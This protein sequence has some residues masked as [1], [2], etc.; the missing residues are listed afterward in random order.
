MAGR[1]IGRRDFLRLAAGAG[2]GLA[3]PGC[4]HGASPADAKAAPRFE[5]G[6]CQWA[7]HEGFQRGERSALEFPSLVAREHRVAGLDW[8]STLFLR[9]G[10][11]TSAAPRDAQ[12]FAEL[13][14]RSDDAGLRSGLIL[15]D[16]GPDVPPMGARAVA[17]RRRFS[18]AALAWVEPARQLGCAGFRVNAHAEAN[19]TGDSE[20]ALDACAEGLEDLLARGRGADLKI[21]VENH[22]GFSSRGDWLAA[23]MRRVAHHPHTGVV[24]DLGNWTEQHL[25]PELVAEIS[26]RLRERG[27]AGM[28]SVRELIPEGA[29]QEYPPLQGMREIAPFARAVSAKSHAF[30]AAGNETSIDFPA[31]LRIL[32][33]AG[34]RG[35]TTAEYEGPGDPSLG[36]ERTLALLRRVEGELA[37]G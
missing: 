28:A 33:Q 34:F 24:A 37:S 10:S 30:D 8:V 19:G 1:G 26:R 11:P 14:R 25:S 16:F 6:V 12:F 4:R 2:A 31:Q 7:Y 29:V 22:G 13:R 23:L 9:R 15:V 21:L 35:W 20:A 27:E 3:L 32:A 17:D 36:T 5:L 18:E